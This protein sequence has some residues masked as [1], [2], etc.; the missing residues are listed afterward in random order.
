MRASASSRHPSAAGTWRPRSPSYLA[1]GEFRPDAEQPI[2]FSESK[3]FLDTGDLTFWDEKR[4][5]QIGVYTSFT[6]KG[7]NNVLWD[8]D[9]K[10]YLIGKRVTDAFLADMRVPEI[11]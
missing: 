4:D 6:T 2:W 3:M 5:G 10:F 9:R 1:L 11:D 8:C 7:G